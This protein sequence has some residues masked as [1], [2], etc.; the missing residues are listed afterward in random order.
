M[1]E[2]YLVWQSW[3]G[4]FRDMTVGFS[5]YISLLFCY[6]LMCFAYTVIIKK[7]LNLQEENKELKATIEGLNDYIKLREEI[8]NTKEFKKNE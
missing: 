4:C 2:R 1:Q 7:F 6:V 8:E 5:V 3:K